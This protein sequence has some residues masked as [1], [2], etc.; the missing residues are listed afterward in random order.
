MLAGYIE[1]TLLDTGAASLTDGFLIALVLAFVTAIVARRS[2][3][4]HSYTNYAPTLLTTLGILG[5]FAGIITGLLAF[6]IENIDASIGELLG[7]LKTAFTTSL[8]GMALSITYKL[9]V[10]T[11]WITPGASEHID[12]EEIG[13]AELYGVMR[14]QSTG[15]EALRTAIG[16]DNEASLVGQMKLMRS[17]VGDNHKK[18]AREMES[19]LTLLTKI[20]VNSEKQA[21]AFAE[22]QDRLWIKLQD[23]AD[24]MSK[25]A[26]EQVINA[27]KDVISDFNKHLVDQFGENFKQLNAAVLE[28]V[29]WQENYKQQLLQMTEQYQQGV[30][31]IT[32]TETAVAH[33]SE[34]SRA[35]PASMQALKSVLEVNQHQLNEL[36]RHLDAF[37]DIR[38][39]AVEAVPEIRKQITE[40]VEG[41]AAATGHLTTGV[42]ESADQLKAAIVEGSEEFV[43]NSQLVNDSLSNTSSM[44]TDNTE[45]TRQ[46]LDD[47]LTETNAVLR[48][49]VA[50]LKDDCGKL[51]E[52]Y[53]G[54]SESLVSETEQ[55]K[56]RFEE[57]L[58]NMR[59]RLSEDMQRLIEQQAQE[60]QRVLS[61]MSR[62]ADA[63]LQDTAE[64]VQKQVKALDDALSHEM[65]RVMTEMGKALAT[66]SGKFTSDYESLVAGMNKI[67]QLRG[68]GES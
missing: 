39:R 49:L 52:S 46:L 9:L 13:I 26:T 58:G 43:R 5:T 29:R 57:S 68:A 12:E 53:R 35:I 6:N 28:L 59:N 10:A 67:V 42:A 41:M 31:A 21:A 27:L 61:G 8:V 32:Q 16:G 62:H 47:A 45:Q 18:T 60:N 3:R 2:N 11:G 1:K 64:S 7:G 4:A 22:F 66:I 33:I 56:V 40:T 24:M 15:I 23:F 63:A 37:K 30:Q 50:D 25:S 51:T 65:S 17:D 36:E 14:E 19:V 44:V 20:S 48:V 55:M 38:D 34:E 54:A